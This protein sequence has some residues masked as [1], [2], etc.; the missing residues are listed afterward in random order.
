MNLSSL[1]LTRLNNCSTHITSFFNFS[2]QLLYI[3]NAQSF[4]FVCFCISSS[5]HFLGWTSNWRSQQLKRSIFA[6]PR[7]TP[8]HPYTRMDQWDCSLNISPHQP[9]LAAKVS[10]SGLGTAKLLIKARIDLLFHIY[11]LLT[12]MASSFQQSS[13]H[14]KLLKP[15]C[16][17][18]I[19]MAAFQI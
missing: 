7:K 18:S 10:L 3:F 6:S 15:I 5:L 13:N 11:F 8:R 19:C 1:F 2:L 4:G 9:W 12:I 17:N 16:H 14:G